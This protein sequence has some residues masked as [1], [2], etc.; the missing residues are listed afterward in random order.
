MILAI[1]NG[2]ASSGARACGVCDTVLEEPKDFCKD[3]LTLNE[4]IGQ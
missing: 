3:S 2:R 1:R 4:E